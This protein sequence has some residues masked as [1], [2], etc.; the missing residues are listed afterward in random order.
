MRTTNLYGETRTIVCSISLLFTLVLTTSVGRH[1]GCS[2]DRRDDCV[3]A[4]GRYGTPRQN[5]GRRV[6]KDIKTNVSSSICSLMVIAFV[7]EK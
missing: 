1:Y 6:G 3:G 4:L 7:E 2:F 5:R